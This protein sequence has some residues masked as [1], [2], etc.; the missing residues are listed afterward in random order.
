MFKA[1]YRFP[2]SLLTLMVAGGCVNIK[3]FQNPTTPEPIG[4]DRYSA[5]I[6]LRS[7]SDL[8]QD[9]FVF[10]DQQQKIYRA[11]STT[12]MKIIFSCI[13]PDDKNSII[14]PNRGKLLHSKF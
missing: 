14:R 4:N 12:G 7:Q 11:I 3:G 9:L 2:F 10:C 8:T 6:G 1:R 5:S 13:D